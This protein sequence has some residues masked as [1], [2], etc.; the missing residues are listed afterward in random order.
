MSA[1]PHESQ[2]GILPL[3][4]EQQWHCRYPG[5]TARSVRWAFYEPEPKPATEVSRLKKAIVALKKIVPRT[6]K[7]NAQEGVTTA[8]ESKSF[9]FDKLPFELK[10]AIFDMIQLTPSWI[11]FTFKSGKL[12]EFE[13]GNQEIY[14]NKEWYRVP[15]LRQ[16]LSR[17]NA[18]PKAKEFVRAFTKRILRS[19][20]IDEKSHPDVTEEEVNGDPPF[21]F[22]LKQRTISPRVRRRVDWFFFDGIV[23]MRPLNSTWPMP[24]DFYTIR[25]CVVRLDHLYEMVRS[26]DWGGILPP[27]FIW[28]DKSQVEEL[29][30]LVGEF[31]KEVPPSNMKQIRAF[32]EDELTEKIG[33]LAID[34][35]QDIP[36]S[37]NFMMGYITECWSVAIL[38]KRKHRYDWL[39]TMN[40]KQWLAY[41]V[42]DEKN[43]KSK[44]LAC[45]EGHRWLDSDGSEFLA[46]ESGWWWLASDLGY[47]WLDTE[48]GTRWLDTKDGGRFLD[49]PQALLWAN[50]GTYDPSEL[51]PLGTQVRKSWCKTPAGREWEF[52]HC[53]NGN[54]PIPPQRPQRASHTLP[55]GKVPVFFINIS[56]RGWR[57]VMCPHDGPAQKHEPRLLARYLGR[58]IMENLD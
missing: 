2:S 19:L 16:G 49:S 51:T 3:S 7:S 39:K 46:S 25:H 33:R 20:R 43:N 36:N 32:W 42:H 29:I 27:Y 34:Y 5:F 45:P 56:F 12:A 24:Y 21:C 23:D 40:G 1:T 53:P 37:D 44:W 57:Y 31:R 47:P 17:I 55:D 8:Q 28:P 14:V 50:I 18:K 41:K 10:S 35:G 4:D 54:P 30:I 9:K 26:N 13:G 15:K 58:N 22:K 6:R 52:S 11:H 48:R 38:T